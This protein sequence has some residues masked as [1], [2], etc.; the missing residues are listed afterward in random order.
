[1]LG[2]RFHQ[3]DHGG[4]V[5]PFPNHRSCDLGI[6]IVNKR[7]TT[8]L[9][10]RGATTGCRLWPGATDVGPQPNVRSRG[11]I[12][13]VAHS[14]GG[15]LGG[16]SRCRTSPQ[17]GAGRVVTCWST[18]SFACCSAVK[19][20]GLTTAGGDNA[21]LDV[22]WMMATTRHP[23]CFSSSSRSMKWSR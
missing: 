3:P 12:A 11:P 21:R 2:H 19:S 16:N 20:S 23:S 17:S 10:G 18:V 6:T 8:P 13:T 15:V 1:M 5:G 22:P 14:C 9:F 4:R 7:L